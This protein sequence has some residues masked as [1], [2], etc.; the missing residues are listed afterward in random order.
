[1]KRATGGPKLGLKSETTWRKLP[2]EVAELVPN[3]EANER[4]LVLKRLV[5]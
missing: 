1:M 4:F 3:R 5:A 2:R